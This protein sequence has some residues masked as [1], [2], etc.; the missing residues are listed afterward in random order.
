M[1]WS[2]NGEKLLGVS[3]PEEILS[4]M[5]VGLSLQG[6]EGSHY[7]IHCVEADRLDISNVPPD[8]Y[9]LQLNNYVAPMH[10]DAKIRSSFSGL[11]T[12]LDIFHNCSP[13][14]FRLNECYGN[15]EIVYQLVKYLSD[16]K[17]MK[18]KYPVQVVLGYF[19]SKIPFGTQIG[20]KIIENHNVWLHSWHVW[21]YVEK[22]LVDM[23]MFKHGGMLP[24]GGNVTSWGSSK[25]H[26]VINPPSGIQYC[27]VAFA[28]YSKF[29][30][31]FSRTIGFRA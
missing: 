19:S 15:A 4:A 11:Q 29:K 27:G 8:V 30:E 3:Q 5:N 26:V 24:P 14:C 2:Y 7:Y 13:P 1:N 18:I 10:I 21:N 25:E 23:S 31:V 17:A 6:I 22:L 12:N 20:D 16:I 28:D 9:G